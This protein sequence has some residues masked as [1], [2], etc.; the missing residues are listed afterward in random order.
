MPFN[1]QVLASISTAQ[2]QA[3]SHSGILYS[4]FVYLLPT[5]AMR[6]PFEKLLGG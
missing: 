1:P 5:A 6:K 4:Q 2:A 3:N